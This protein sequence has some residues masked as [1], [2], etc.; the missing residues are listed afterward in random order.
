MQNQSKLL[1]WSLILGIVIV[2]N[3][4]INY[5]LSLVYSEPNYNDFCPQSYAATPADVAQETICSNN[6]TAAYD[7][8]EAE[9]FGTLV[10]IG[11]IL[12]I[13]SFFTKA[14]PVLGTAL[15]LT[16]VLSLV[17]ASFRYWSQAYGWVR[18]LILA[19]ALAALIYV[20]IK[21][22]SKKSDE[23]LRS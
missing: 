5:S 8:Y 11:V 9:V 1:K 4:F 3:L 18:V 22:F 23:A 21:K 2:A 17:I 13:L 14:N 12:V 16:G 10:A 6:Y 7:N 19:V 20:A 15:S